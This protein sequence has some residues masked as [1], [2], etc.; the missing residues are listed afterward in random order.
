MMEPFCIE[1][2]GDNVAERDFETLLQSIRDAALPISALAQDPVRELVRSA[3]LIWGYDPKQNRM[4]LFYGRELLEDIAKG[5]ASEFAHQMLL[6]FTI[7]LTTDEPESLRA[8]VESLK[9]SC[10]YR[11]AKRNGGD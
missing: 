2:R 6:C 1:G 3:G 11:A 5:R 8:A 10:C 4:P 9:G 7:D